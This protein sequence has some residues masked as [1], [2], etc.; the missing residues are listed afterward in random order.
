MTA[1]MFTMEIR[2][3]GAPL[4]LEGTV[5]VVEWMYRGRHDRWRI[6]VGDVVIGEGVG[7]PG[8]PLAMALV[9]DVLWPE[10][11]LAEVNQR[12]DEAYMSAELRHRIFGGRKVRRGYPA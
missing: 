1:P 10:F 7:D 6:E 11:L 12:D 5:G 8:I 9:M 4:L 2:C 3:L